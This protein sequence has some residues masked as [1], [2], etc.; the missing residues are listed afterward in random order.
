MQP[1]MST[2]LARGWSLQR[3]ALEEQK[4]REIE[5][6]SWEESFDSTNC[7]YNFEAF[8]EVIAWQYRILQ[9]NLNSAVCPSVRTQGIKIKDR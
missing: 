6:L 8:F 7:S 9:L 3:D 5:T 4:T 2:Q 1:S